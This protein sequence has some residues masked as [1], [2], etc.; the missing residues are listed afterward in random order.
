MLSASAQTNHI[1]AKKPTAKDNMPYITVGDV[2]D[3]GITLAEIIAANKLTFLNPDTK[4]KIT[5][6][7]FT[8]NKGMILEYSGTDE[9][10]TNEI[11]QLLTVNPP[12]RGSFVW[13]SDITAESETKEIIKLNPIVLRLK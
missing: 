12:K 3:G 11:I 10:F 2:Y 1:E 7:T 8:F 6:Y 4:L 5:H 13:I 9:K